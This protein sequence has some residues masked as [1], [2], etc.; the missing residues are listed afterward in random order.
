MAINA[1]D[2]KTYTYA[3]YLKFTDDEPVEIIDGRISAMSPVPSRIHQEI[4]ME[5]AYEIKIHTQMNL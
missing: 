4:I 2:N 5:I 1:I 3:D